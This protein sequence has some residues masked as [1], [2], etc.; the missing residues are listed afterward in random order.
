MVRRRASKKRGAGRY[1][2][3]VCFMHLNVRMVLERSDLSVVGGR[4]F[5][6]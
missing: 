6:A 2:S 3:Y 5:K 4:G 1:K